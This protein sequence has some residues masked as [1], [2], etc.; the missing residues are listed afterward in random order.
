M[1]FNC[2]S[3]VLQI[4]LMGILLNTFLVPFCFS[5]INEEKKEKIKLNST[6]EWTQD[7]ETRSI[8]LAPF[9]AYIDGYSISIESINPIYDL[10]I[11]IVNNQNGNEVYNA[12]IE[13]EASNYIL[14]PIN[15]L[16]D[17]EYSL[18]IS[19]MNSNS[20]AYGYFNK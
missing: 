3:R 9:N 12:Q 10:E 18:T 17:G 11:S 2:I 1:K 7:A 5:T 16:T 20:R 14:I 4:A 8:I 13:K 15:N 19:D 6:G